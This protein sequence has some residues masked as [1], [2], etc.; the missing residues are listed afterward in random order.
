MKHCCNILCIL[1]LALALVPTNLVA[2]TDG[3]A[4]L[5]ATILDYTGTTSPNHYT[6]VW[7]TTQAGAFIKSLRKQGPSSWTS[8]EWGNHCG[9]WNTARA[10]STALDGYSTATAH[11][12][13][14]ETFSGIGLVTNSPIILTWNC[15]DA[16]NNLMPDGN[17]KFWI[18]YAENSGQGPVTTGGLLWTKGITGATNTYANQGANFANMKVTWSPVIPPAPPTPPEFTSFQIIGHDLVL[19]GTGPTNGLYTVLIAN[20]ANALSAQWTSIATNSCDA[21]GQFR[22]TNT[23]NT[24]ISARFYRLRVH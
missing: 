4:K 24:G 19:S 15:R 1:S 11:N 20:E 8:S 14:S 17:Y 5:E 16:S 6:V 22:F 18:Q 23:I 9:T 2:Q 10:G 3:A 13:T 7:V 21:N 12:Y